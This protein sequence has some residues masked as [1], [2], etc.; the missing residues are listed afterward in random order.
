MSVVFQ[1]RLEWERFSHESFIFIVFVSC[2]DGWLQEIDSFV[3]VFGDVKTISF[4]GFLQLIS[5]A[6][7]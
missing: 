6:K 1:M 3:A 4:T 5:T 2:S 7:L